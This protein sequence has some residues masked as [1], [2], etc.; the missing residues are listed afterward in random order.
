MNWL[1]SSVSRNTNFKVGGWVSN[2]QRSSSFTFG[3]AIWTQYQNRGVVFKE[4]K[5]HP[6]RNRWPVALIAGKLKWPVV[7]I[8]HRTF[9]M[10][11]LRVS[12][13]ATMTSTVA[14]H[15]I[16][17][18]CQGFYWRLFVGFLRVYLKA[19]S[20]IY[21][22]LNH[23]IYTLAFVLRSRIVLYYFCLLARYE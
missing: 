10:S 5:E 20:P 8:S 21:R 3:Y 15:Q 17:M 6:L 14:I 7:P 23:L 22:V 19:Q 16:N 1:M 18:N 9:P 2:E 4:R 11:Q 13:F 12:F